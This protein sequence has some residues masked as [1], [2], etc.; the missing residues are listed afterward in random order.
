MSLISQFPKIGGPKLRNFENKGTKAVI[1]PKNYKCIFFY[2]ILILNK[3]KII[4]NK[5]N[6]DYLFQ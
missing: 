5:I 6:H 2:K 4:K 3:N 1:K